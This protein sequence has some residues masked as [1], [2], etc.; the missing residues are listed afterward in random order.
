[1]PLQMYSRKNNE[2]IRARSRYLFQRNFI[3][4]YKN[5]DYFF[6]K[7]IGKSCTI[8]MQDEIKHILQNYRYIYTFNVINFNQD[9]I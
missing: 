7:Y 8:F 2:Y 4:K 9:P 3:S 1:M 5:S 6:S